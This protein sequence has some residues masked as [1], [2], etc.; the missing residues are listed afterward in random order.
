MDQQNEIQPNEPERNSNECP[1]KTNEPTGAPNKLNEQR[2]PTG[3]PN[4]PRINL[5]SAQETSFKK[6]RRLSSIA[7]LCAVV[8][9]F[10]GGMLLSTAGLVC[11]FLC[12]RTLKPH[13]NDP[14]DGGTFAIALKRT[15]VV[16]AMFC[17]M[18]FALN[19]FAAWQMMPM[20][21]DMLNSG[22]LNLEGASPSPSNSTWG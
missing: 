17:A 2:N 4:G 9:L 18:S 19:A 1:N 7:M 10:F 5:T 12:Y 15:A 21:M 3:S 8:S 6:A 22:N 14:G 13:F 20:I 16:S 11:A